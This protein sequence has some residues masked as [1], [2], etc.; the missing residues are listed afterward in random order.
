MFG[1]NIK[2]S[3][4]KKE[5]LCTSVQKIGVSEFLNVFGMKSLLCLLKNTVKTVLL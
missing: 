3:S 2:K 1:V 5:L 4:A